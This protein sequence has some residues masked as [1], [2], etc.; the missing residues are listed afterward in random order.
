M[1]DKATIHV[2][3]SIRRLTNGGGTFGSMRG[4]ADY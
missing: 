3:F 4:L 1:N 2:R